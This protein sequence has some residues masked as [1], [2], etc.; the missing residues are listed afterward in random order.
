MAPGLDEQ[1]EKWRSEGTSCDAD[2]YLMRYWPQTK[3]GSEFLALTVALKE[4]KFTHYQRF[5]ERHVGRS[6]LWGRMVCKF[7]GFSETDSVMP[8]VPTRDEFL[9]GRPYF[10]NGDHSI[11][12][13]T[14]LP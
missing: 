10:V 9:A 13:G 7:Y 14:K 6:D 4:P 1:I 11:V 5:M 8:S 2:V 3:D 12:F